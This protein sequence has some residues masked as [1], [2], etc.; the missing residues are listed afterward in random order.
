VSRP[1]RV[2]LSV[3]NVLGQRVATLIDGVIAAGSYPVQWNGTDTSGRGVSSG[4]Y[5]VRMNTEE[6][7]HTSKIM[8]V[9]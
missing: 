2:N 6:G 3:Y 9:R 5:F 1:Q 8:L 4:T 7:I